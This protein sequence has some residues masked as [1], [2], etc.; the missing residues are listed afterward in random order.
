VTANAA[1]LGIGVANMSLGGL[2]PPLGSCA[3]TTDAVHRAICEST[4]AGVTYVVAAGNWGD[5][6]QEEPWE[7]DHPTVPNIP[8]AYPEVLTVTAIADSD[9]AAGGAGAAIDCGGQVPDDSPAPF[10][11]FAATPAGAA[12][13]IAAPGC[14]IRSTHTG[15]SGYA[16]FSGTSM[17]TPHVAG[18]VALCIDEAGVEGECAGLDPD[19]VIDHVRA[20]A[21]AY[22]EAEH[23][24]AGNALGYGFLGDPLNQPGDAYYGF[25][26][27]APGAPTSDPGAPDDPA[28]PGD[29]GGD[30][31]PSETGDGP[32]G[33][34]GDSTEADLPGAPAD[35][36]SGDEAASRGENLPAA[37]EITRARVRGKRANRRL[38]VRGSLDPAAAGERIVVRFRA[39]GRQIRI[40]SLIRPDGSFALVR[41]LR[42]PQRAA[43]AGRLAI[44]YRGNEVLRPAA[45]RLRAA[46]RPV[47]LR[48]TGDSPRVRGTRVIVAGR[49][50]RTAGGQV[51]ITVEFNR[52]DGSPGDVAVRAAVDDRGR[53]RAAVRIPAAGRVAGAHVSLTHRGRA[54]LHGQRIGRGLPG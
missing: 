44:R 40:R 19:Q 24:C 49:V 5:G 29:S 11:N 53:F 10:S 22:N 48:L 42:G 25:L 54:P 18:V 1:E 47:R 2:G 33:G 14:R 12:H 45:E 35:G 13:T 3:T 6:E 8:A 26:T 38:V 28:I 16:T 46:R 50:R 7:F 4:G 9:G 31:D 15:A 32:D 23:P 30:S 20:D 51:R 21:E 17:A 27:V 52:A 34:A 36:P 43:R 41:R 39:R 37:L